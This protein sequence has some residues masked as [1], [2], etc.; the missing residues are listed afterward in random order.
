MGI[1]DI[2]ASLGVKGG[3]HIWIEVRHDFGDWIRL[4]TAPLPEHGD[5]KFENRKIGDGQTEPLGHAGA[6]PFRD[7]RTK[8][9]V[10]SFAPPD[11]VF[12]VRAEIRP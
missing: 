2:L 10:A 6:N 9:R 7:D 5:V 12:F 11:P 8:P 3:E 4:I 1:D